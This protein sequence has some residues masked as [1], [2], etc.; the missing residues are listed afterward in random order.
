MKRRWIVATPLPEDL[1][2]DGKEV[3]QLLRSDAERKEKAARA[4]SFIYGVGERSLD[5]H[6]RQPLRA[7]GV[8][9]ITRRALDVA[10]DLA[11]KGIRGPM[12]RVLEGMDEEQLLGVARE[13]E[14]R[15]Y[16][17]PHAS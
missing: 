1:A 13:I 5:F 8:G 11:L 3:V 2:R 14:H 6:F 16:P 4:F 9:A 17:D 10:L 15:L 7:L 12:R